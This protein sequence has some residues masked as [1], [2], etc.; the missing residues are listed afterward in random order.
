MNRSELLDAIAICEAAGLTKTP[1]ENHILRAL[2]RAPFVSVRVSSDGG[3]DDPAPPPAQ[4]YETE[5]VV[6]RA[7]RLPA[8]ATD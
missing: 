8:L 1:V 3:L 6:R 5:G 4:E 2:L 7:R